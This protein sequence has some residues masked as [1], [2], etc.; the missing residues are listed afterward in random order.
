MA[1]PKTPL[2]TRDRVIR[3]ALRT[4]D[5]HGIEGLNMRDLAEDLGVNGA[6]FYH[7]FENKQE[8]VEGVVLYIMSSFPWEDE[9][10]PWQDAV[11]DSLLGWRR[12]M[13]KHPNV[14]PLI[15]GINFRK[16]AP[17]LTENMANRMIRGG[18]PPEQ[19]LT[20]METIEFIAIGSALTTATN[21]Y[22]HYIEASRQNAGIKTML[23]ANTYDDEERFERALRSIVAGF[24]S[25]AGRRVR[26]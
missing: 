5:R 9:D 1:R 10:L 4:I 6:S 21:A 20:L 26:A 13:L 2:I 16:V 18:V 14:V 15:A 23:D 19:V 3:A 11:V 24:S 17:E 12:A 7:H 25:K 8:I 22:E